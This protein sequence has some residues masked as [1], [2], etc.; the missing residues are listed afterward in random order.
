MQEVGRKKAKPFYFDSNR[1]VEKMCVTIEDLDKHTIKTWKVARESLKKEI[2]RDLKSYIYESQSTG[3]GV[4]DFI[5]AL[6]EL[7]N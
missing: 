2:I 7:Y 6:K 3:V 4:K 1:T 5:K